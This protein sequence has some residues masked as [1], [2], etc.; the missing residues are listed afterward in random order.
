[1]TERWDAV[2]VGSGP[3]GLAAAI[4]L[5]RADRSV[6]LLEGADRI[7]GGLWSEEVESGLVRDRGAAVMPF[8][9]GSPFLSGLDLEGHGLRWAFPKVQ[10][11]HPLDGG[12]AGA[13]LR[14]I[15]ETAA[16]LGSDGARY[17]RLLRPFVR[18]WFDLAAEV[19]QP[20]VHLP[21]HPLL[22]ARYGLT[23]LPSSRA[24]ARIFEHDET[25]GMLA[26]CAAHGVLPL[27]APFTAAFATIFAASAHAVGWPVAVGGS[28][29]VADAMASL[30]RALG[31]EIRTGQPVRTLA[32]VPPTTAV[33]FD[34]NP[35]QLA[36][37]CGD[38]LP[39]RYRRRLRRYRFG[40]GVFKVD[41]VLDGPVPWADP[42][43]GASATIHVGGTFEETAAAEASVARG[44]HPDRPFV[45]VA[46]QAIADP[47]RA[48]DGRQVLWA[49]THVPNGS[50]VDCCEAI[51]RQIE[52]FAPGFRD[53][54]VE[55]L[56][57]T[58][59]ELEAANPNLVGGDITGG[60]HAGTQLFARPRLLR[61]YRT[62]NP[63][64]FLCSA[65]TPPGGGIH[66]M[67][68]HHA[69]DV[70]LA[71]I[72]GRASSHRAELDG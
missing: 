28:Q 22:L 52:R 41:F 72:L 21:R 35:H 18:R 27:T 59:A 30:L 58:T 68:G 25:R 32:D 50:T 47:S 53:R 46:Q 20:I 34:V 66:G 19:Q 2:V 65:S 7:G 49:Y 29:A 10:Y 61:P 14:D 64:L 63:A 4:T 43:S 45:L 11:S 16:L 56:R 54:I 60:T 57:T 42:H 69:A 48:R 37:I 12:R 6:L 33:L 38:E 36:T 44:G 70:A 67:P 26:G 8:A 17:R 5:A 71:G 15:D 40:P 3:N 31:G 9:V 39:D 24:L 13:A 51:E 1:M 62:P 55:R 23:G